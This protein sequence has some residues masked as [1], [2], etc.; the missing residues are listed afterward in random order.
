MYINI[1][2]IHTT[3]ISLFYDSALDFFA[4]GNVC[5]AAAPAAAVIVERATTT[6]KANQGITDLNLL[7]F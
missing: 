3:V 5:C 4:V 1:N 7:L 2:S 6:L